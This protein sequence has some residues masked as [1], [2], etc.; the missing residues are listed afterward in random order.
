[1][2]GDGTPDVLVGEPAALN[3]TTSISGYVRVFDGPTGNE[4]FRFS[5]AEVGERFGYAVGAAVIDDNNVGKANVAGGAYWGFNTA[6]TWFAG[7]V[8]IFASPP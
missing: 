2:D 3:N 1:V 4:L 7:S 5:G 6:T 8:R